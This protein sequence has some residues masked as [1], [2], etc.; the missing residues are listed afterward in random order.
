MAKSKYGP[1]NQVVVNVGRDP[2]EFDTKVGP[3]VRFSVA[4]NMGYGDD[5]PPPR[6]VSVAVFNDDIRPQ[7]LE[8]IRKGSRVALEGTITESEY[9]GKTQYNMVAVRV[10]L[11]EWF[12]R[13]QSGNTTGRKDRD[14]DEPDGDLGW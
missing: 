8:K 13:S 12:L 1:L 10:G 9:E 2:E 3:V 4:R 14:E 5:A 11:I 7:V 6:W